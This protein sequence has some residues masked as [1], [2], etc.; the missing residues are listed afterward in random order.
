MGFMAPL[1]MAGMALSAVGAGANFLEKRKNQNK[2]EAMQRKAGKQIDRNTAAATQRWGES[3]Q[4]LTKESQQTMSDEA[5]A[6]RMAAYE[7]ATS[8]IPEATNVMQTNEGAPAIVKAEAAKQLGNQLAS[9]RGMMQAK[10]RLGAW[11]DRGLDTN[12]M[13][14]RSGQDIA[15]L[16][17]FS[18]GTAEELDRNVAMQANKTNGI[19]DILMGVG[20]LAGMAGGIGGVGGES[21]LAGVAGPFGDAQPY[22]MISPD[23]NWWT[24]L[25]TPWNAKKVVNYGGD[26]MGPPMPNF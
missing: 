25:T 4:G 5:A 20:S 11:G 6:K 1:A 19:G 18:L 22:A 10:S 21:Q 23:A 15:R 7:E 13:L 24:R 9:L 26:P 16:G 12:I 2:I 3:L 8:D 14:G 17:N